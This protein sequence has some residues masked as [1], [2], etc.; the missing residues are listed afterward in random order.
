MA[1]T[2]PD[3]AADE[4]QRFLTVGGDS[5]GEVLVVAYT[6]RAIAFG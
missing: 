2:I 3:P 5:T 1:I 4:E 6:W